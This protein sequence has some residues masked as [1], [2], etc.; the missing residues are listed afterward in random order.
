MIDFWNQLM[1]AVSSKNLKQLLKILTPP[2]GVK[3]KD[4]NGP[5]APVDKDDELFDCEREEI[6]TETIDEDKSTSEKEDET[7]QATSQ[8]T[9]NDP[10]PLNDAK[11]IDKMGQFL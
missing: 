8:T 4:A 3:R 2:K 5:A 6:E 10:K 11:F 9:A 7:P 1:K